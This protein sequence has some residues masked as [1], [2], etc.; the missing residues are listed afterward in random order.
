MI[1]IP[2]K[3]LVQLA[4]DDTTPRREFARRALKVSS[5]N[6]SLH[7][8]QKPA[9]AGF[10]LSKCRALRSSARSEGVEMMGVAYNSRLAAARLGRRPPLAVPQACGTSLRSSTPI[11]SKAVCFLH[12]TKSIPDG[13]F[14]V[15]MMGV[16]PMSKEEATKTSTSVL[17]MNEEFLLS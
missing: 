12:S 17:R 8:S 13:I 10:W 6:P 2:E 11:E 1:A 5:I 4:A 3:L 9:D 15:E 14:F 7:E 16:E